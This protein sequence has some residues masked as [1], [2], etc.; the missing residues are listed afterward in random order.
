MRRTLSQGYSARVTPPFPPTL[1][2]TLTLALGLGACGAPEDTST[3]GTGGDDV[4]VDDTA[5]PGGTDTGEALEDT[6]F[7]PI[8]FAFTETW[9][10]WDGETLG[11]WQLP[12]QEAQAPRMSLDLYGAAW[13]SQ[14]DTSDACRVTLVLEPGAEGAPEAEVEDPLWLGLHATLLVEESTCGDF[15]TVAWPDG[16]PV[17]HLDG[18]Q[19]WM[20]YGPLSSDLSQYLPHL[21]EEQGLDWAEV[22]PF[23]FGQAV[24][25]VDP[26]S[27]QPL[28]SWCSW[29]VAYEADP[30][31]QI[32]TD[33]AGRPT[34]LAPGEALP[35]G[36]LRSYAWQSFDIR[37]LPSDEAP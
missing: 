15:S 37:A 3:G 1:S 35:E 4:D 17:A 14:G 28:V 19:L 23:I 6:G 5:A 36:V 30:D 10:G 26:N 13:F 25:L 31:G 2:L 34:L 29:A 32:F 9:A 24:E 20:G 21:F 18:V 8:V 12:D 27:G 33:E 16:S 7:A 22:E 11:A